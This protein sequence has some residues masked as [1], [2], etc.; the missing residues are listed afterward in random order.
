M[1]PETTGQK[2]LKVDRMAIPDW[3]KVESLV[4]VYP[5]KLWGRSHLV[6][7][8]NNLIDSLPNDLKIIVLVKDE[9]V[10]KRIHRLFPNRN[11]VTHIIEE[12]TDIWIRDYA[13]LCVLNGAYRHSAKFLYNPKY[14]KKNDKKYAESDHNAGKQLGKL[15][16]AFTFVDADIIWD[17]G[18]LTHNGNGT[19]IISNRIISDNEEFSITELKDLLHVFCGFNRIIF[20]PVEPGDKTGHVDGMVRFLNEKTLVV[21]VY[22]SHYKDAPFLG[23]LARSLQE[24][25]GPEYKII[26]VLNSEPE[27]EETERIASAVGNHV[28]FL[29]LQDKIYFPYYSDEI[30]GDSLK[31]FI[32]ELKRL[33][34]DI[35]V[36]PVNIPEIKDLAKLG[37][38]L[39]CITWQL[40]Q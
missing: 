7:F 5:Q 35:K 27:V 1:D 26:R 18:N 19:A 38:V 30:S 24:Q 31:G 39:N 32:S 25:L 3:G 22:P 16:N 29:R 37:G 21:G 20:V 28:N 14:Y 33:E 13:P 9:E 2:E 10:D 23:R 4:L 36:H 17:L 8:Y 15:L 6:K 12:V 34:L 40:L 11:F